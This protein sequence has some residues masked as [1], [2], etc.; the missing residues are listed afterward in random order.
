V[1]SRISCVCTSLFDEQ[2]IS[3]VVSG[4]GDLVRALPVG[5]MWTVSTG[6]QK[7][8]TI[9]TQYVGVNRDETWRSCEGCSLRS[10]NGGGCY[11]WAGRASRA[12]NSVRGAYE[13]G[14]PST[15]ADA[16]ARAPRSAKACR[17]GAIGDPART[18]RSVLLGQLELA[19]E[20]GFK[21][22]GYTHFAMQEPIT[23]VLRHNFLA[24]CETAAQ[25]EEA[26]DRGWLIALAGPKAF[27]GMLTCP[28]YKRPEIQCNRCTLCDVP[29]LRKTRYAGI[30]FPA[31]GI[32]A[33]RLP[34]A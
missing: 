8:G 21:V 33:K 31:H 27:P 30:V 20:E 34:L 24:S 28:N 10:D 32:S 2:S 16:I 23:G 4:T 14:R 3:P 25:V 17:W 19:R 6:N 12:A 15:L 29:T 22:L 1:K 18:R 9:P 11:A 13:R 5:D 26:Q 7:T